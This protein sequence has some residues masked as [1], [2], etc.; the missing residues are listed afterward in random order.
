MAMISYKILSVGYF[1]VEIY[2]KR[3][4]GHLNNLQST[5]MAFYLFL[6]R[7]LMEK[8]QPMIPVVR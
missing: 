5:V 7:K 2:E 3:F 8:L 4:H 6:E 1:Y